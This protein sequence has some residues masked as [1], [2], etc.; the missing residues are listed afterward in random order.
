M[1]PP[2]RTKTIPSILN[3]RCDRQTPAWECFAG[4]GCSHANVPLDLS[5]SKTLDYQMQ[6]GFLPARGRGYNAIAFDNFALTNDW[7]ACGAFKGG[8]TGSAWVQLYS[9]APGHT[10][11]PR[12]D[13]AYVH[14]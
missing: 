7:G 5:N 3:P 2:C 4:E 8:S 12:I 1:L 11:P 10:A 6:A 14:S 13:P 9:P